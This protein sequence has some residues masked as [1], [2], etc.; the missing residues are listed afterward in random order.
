VIEFEAVT[1]AYAGQPVLRDVTFAIPEGELLLVVGPTGSGKTSLLRCL[2]A[3]LAADA[4]HGSAQLLGRVLVDG[5]DLHQPTSDGHRP[6]VGL[7]RQDPA[8][9]L[10]E[11]TVESVIAAGVRARDADPHSGQRQVEETLDLLGIA[12]LRSRQVA[13]LSGGQQQRVA[14]GVA[15][16][17]G[18]RVLVLDEPTS[19]L[20]PVAA[21]DVLG[22]LH[23]L[24]HDVGTTVVV[25]EHR[26]ERVV[27]HADAVVL[28]DGGRVRGP[29]DPAA[30][31]A[32]SALRPPVVELGLQL[33]W[34]RVALSVREARRSARVLRA[35]LGGSDGPTPAGAT[36][37][38]ATPAVATAA[39]DTGS[40]TSTATTLVPLV[41][42][43][44]LTVVRD[45]V[46]A[47]RSVALRVEP[48]EVVALMGR[49]GSGKSTLLR[50]LDGSGSPTSGRVAVTGTRARAPQDPGDLLSDRTVAEQLAG[51][52]ST[53]GLVAG[54]TRAVLVR[55]AP[56]LVVDASHGPRP[57]DLSEGQRMSVALSMVLARAT[58]LV[59][60]DEP[61]RGL[62]Y[63]AKARLCAIL[64][65]RAARGHA[66]VVAT[67]D[68][69]LAAEVASRVVVL[70]EGEV[71][72]DG[73]A[74]QVLADSP[75]FAPQVAKVMQP[76]PFLRV[77]EVVAA[78]P[79]D[80]VS[81][82]PLTSR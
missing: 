8:A 76:L 46:I 5:A 60:L 54:T 10:A 56:D 52:D 49:N 48:G 28:V 82:V 3:D 32:V 74:V 11:G 43:R 22:I 18:P 69:E 45:G 20:D 30:A 35:I 33:G 29:L 65:E 67:H 40:P 24:V 39:R 68:V 75:A 37:G 50:T 12:D 51:H 16:V 73:P 21:E 4:D 7:V 25:A 81:T 9:A 58:E 44:R 23:R 2:D 41:D 36:P 63:A 55:L 27:H 79:P 78:L 38:G 13:D 71:V 1:L 64:A 14:I 59:L 17:A 47:L 72:A 42:V 6:L 34:E 31:M 77:S 53:H 19:A 57:V 61:T 26:L 70:A 66:L 62:D 15:I 80:A